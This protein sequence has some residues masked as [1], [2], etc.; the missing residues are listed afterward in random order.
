MSDVLEVEQE[1][2]RVRGE[3]EQMEADQQA[4]EHRVTFA[5][6]DLRIDEEFRA[7]L[8]TPS[9]L[10]SAEE[11]RRQRISGRGGLTRGDSFFLSDVWTIDSALV[12]DPVPAREVFMETIAGIF[13]S[14]ACRGNRKIVIDYGDFQKSGKSFG[15]LCASL[16]HLLKTVE[17]IGKHCGKL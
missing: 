14:R 2:S 16:P 7:E 3:I 9:F 5:T 12:R 13:I 10:K 8:G 11:C 1:I 15:V 4:L 6:V 17:V